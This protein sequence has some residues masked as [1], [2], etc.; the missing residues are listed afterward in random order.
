MAEIRTVTTL[1]SKAQEIVASINTYERKLNQARADLAHITAIIRIFEASGE[2][3]DVPRYVNL[4]RLFRRHEKTQLCLDALA[5]GELSTR[6]IA[7][8]IASGQR[9][10][11]RLMRPW[12]SCSPRSSFIR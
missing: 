2:A 12:R 1:R 10:S 6:E 9:A 8:Y 7:L 4:H 11:M 3:V 5:A